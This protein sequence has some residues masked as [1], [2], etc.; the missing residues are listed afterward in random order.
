MAHRQSCAHLCTSTDKQTCL[1]AD[2]HR[3]MQAHAHRTMWT[4]LTPY[5][6]RKA[7]PGSQ[8]IQAISQGPG[9][10]GGGRHGPCPSLVLFL[11]PPDSLQCGIKGPRLGSLVLSLSSGSAVAIR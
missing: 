11:H 9:C 7:V 2:A 3:V 6:G 8:D 10:V 5:T 4:Q 1:G